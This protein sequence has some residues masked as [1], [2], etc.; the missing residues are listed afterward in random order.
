M[1]RIIFVTLL[2]LSW[3]TGA[4]AQ[5]S[6]K[7]ISQKPS[8]RDISAFS[9]PQYDKANEILRFAKSD[10]EMPSLLGKTQASAQIV[11]PRLQISNNDTAGELNGII[12]GIGV[13][14]YSRFSF[15]QNYEQEITRVTRVPN[16]TGADAYQKTSTI[17]QLESPIRANGNGVG[18][19]LLFGYQGFLSPFGRVA[20]LGMRVYGDLDVTNIAIS[21]DMDFSALRY[22]V[23]FDAL[24][25]FIITT[26]IRD[27]KK[28]YKVK[29]KPSHFTLGIFTGVRIGGVSYFGKDIRMLDKR[30]QELG[31]GGAFPKGSFDFG[32]NLGLRANWLK[33][34]RV[35][36]VFALPVYHTNYK[37]SNDKVVND[38]TTTNRINGEIRERW[39]IGLPYTYFFSIFDKD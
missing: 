17:T 34:I 23:N 7:Q 27:S 10:K 12:L 5:I 6:Q 16:A 31:N 15:S 36:L 20:Q 21:K 24:L 13:K 14:N 35:E 33:H 2:A 37:A 29:K 28:Y 8:S 32:V 9:K 18:V 22:G 26:G 38:V 30:M 25:N 3:H 4:L 11:D 1:K 19:N 39:S